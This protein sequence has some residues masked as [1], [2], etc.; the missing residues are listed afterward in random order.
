MASDASRRD[1]PLVS[2]RDVERNY[3]GLRPLRV[4]AF[5]LYA[6]QSVAIL[7]MDRAPAEAF[8]NLVSAATLPDSGDV[9]TLG[10]ST[11]SVGSNEDWVSLLDRVGILSERSVLLGEMTAAQNVAMPFSLELL[12]MS[13]ELRA[14]VDVLAEEVG[15]DS[16]T[17]DAPLSGVSLL[18]RA[19]VRLARALAASPAVLLAEHPNA[20]V[21]P[22]EVAAFKT[23]LA[24]VIK[25][26]Q[27]AA[28]TLTA[29]D[30]FARGVATVLLEHNAA[31][32]ALT[33]ASRWR[34]LWS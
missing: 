25:G 12:E 17:L 7:G 2:L 16:R 8:V 15:L 34:R 5:D 11:A 23:D 26:R 13:P 32:G 6:G 19:R 33:P 20:L 14:R 10:R 22:A 27:M 18:D 21:E 3:Y 1:A 28:I 29:D 31:T 9:V 24:R 4:R 30:A